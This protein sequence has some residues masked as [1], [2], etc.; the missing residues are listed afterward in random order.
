MMVW[1][2]SHVGLD[3]DHCSKR[4]LLKTLI[5]AKQF[6]RVI[7][8]RPSRSGY[9]VWI[10]LSQPRPFW[11]HVQI[12]LYLFDDPRRILFDIIRYR[13]GRLNIVDTLWNKKTDLRPNLRIHGMP[14]LHDPLRDRPLS[15]GTYFI[16]LLWNN[17]GRQLEQFTQE[18]IDT[19]ADL[20]K[21]YLPTPTEP[22]PDPEPTE[23]TP[24]TP[25]A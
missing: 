7:S 12:R 8:V 11:D 1:R 18:D 21:K 10:L 17:N 16:Q 22:T 25:A 24:P 20:V 23:T 15:N 14:E 2:A 13:A 19:I 9:H 6:G 4:N 5:K 3:L